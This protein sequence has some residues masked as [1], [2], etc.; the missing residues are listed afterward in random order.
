VF[1]HFN[2]ERWES[3]KKPQI[4]LNSNRKF[5]IFVS[6]PNNPLDAKSARKQSRKQIKNAIP[7]KKKTKTT[8]S[9]NLALLKYL[10]ANFFAKLW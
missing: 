3:I 8:S 9:C 1:D 10:K 7:L 5:V 2:K 6:K 4:K